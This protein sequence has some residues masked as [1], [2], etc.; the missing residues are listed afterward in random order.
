MAG[1][2]LN[3]AATFHP[4]SAIAREVPR[5]Q[6]RQ[7]RR[8]GRSQGD[9]RQAAPWAEDGPRAQRQ[10]GA[11]DEG[12]RGEHA[13]SAVGRGAKP[14]QGFGHVLETQEGRLHGKSTQQK[15]PPARSSSRDAA[16]SSPRN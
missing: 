6:E 5:D 3:S 1:D 14:A 10:R 13:G 7:R 9:E 8:R 2:S 12:Q 4:P 15:R 16:R 11:R